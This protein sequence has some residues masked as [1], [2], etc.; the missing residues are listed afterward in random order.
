[1]VICSMLLKTVAVDGGVG[2]APAGVTVVVVGSVAVDAVVVGAV[3]VGSVVVGAVVVGA[4]VVGAV[5]VG[6]GVCKLAEPLAV[7][8]ALTPPPQA[9]LRNRDNMSTPK[10]NLIIGFDYGPVWNADE[11]A[12][13]GPMKLS[14]SS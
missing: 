6:V 5:V 4:V 10:R 12:D 7:W 1:M 8:L 13:G 3:V 2:S 14:F 11:R 9:T